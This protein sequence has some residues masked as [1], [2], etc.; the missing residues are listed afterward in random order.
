MKPSKRKKLKAAGFKIGSV[1]EF[2]QLS[3]AEMEQINLN[4]RLYE[5]RKA[6]RR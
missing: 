5:T 6:V 4:V 2:L 3:T 1:Q